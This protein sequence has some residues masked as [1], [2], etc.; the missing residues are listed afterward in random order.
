MGYKT[1]SEETRSIMRVVFIIQ[2]LNTG[3]ILLMINADITQ[4]TIYD[5]WDEGRYTDFSVNWYKDV[6][7][8]IISTMIFNIAYPIIEFVLFFSIRLAYRL[9]DNGFTMNSTKTKKHVI[10]DYVDLYSGPEYVIHYKYSFILNVVFMTF[11][12]GAGLPILFPIAVCSLTVLYV[13]ERL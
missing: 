10:I 1:I 4:I 7:G 9:L 5:F 6:A 13:L 2:F 3:P 8:I 12:F 11:T